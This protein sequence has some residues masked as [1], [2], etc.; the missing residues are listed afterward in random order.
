MIENFA[1]CSERLREDSTNQ[2]TNLQSIDPTTGEAI[3]SYAEH[4][5]ADAARMLESAIIAQRQWRETSFAERG[6][7]LKR[8]ATILRRDKESHAVLM[9]REMGK[10]LEQGRAEI[11]KCA[12]CC[13]FYAEHAGKFLSAEEVRTE[14]AHSYVLFQPLGVLL[15]IMPWNFPFWQVIRAAAPALMAGNGMLLKHASNVCGCALA[16]EN[17]F[18]EADLPE[19]LFSALLISSRHVSEVIAHPGVAAVTLTGSTAAGKSV[20]GHAGAHLKK[21]VLELGGSDAYVVLDDADIEAAAEICAISRLINSGQSCI[22]AKRFIVAGAVREMFQ[23]QLVEKMGARKIGN[24]I[25]PGTQIGPL[26]RGDLRD[27]LHSQVQRS[28]VAGAKVLL[29]GKVSPGAGAYYPAT[30]LANV[31]PGMAAFDEETFGPVAAIIEADNEEHAI[32]LANKSIFGLGAA[33]FTSDAT[34]GER[35]AARLEAGCCFINDFVRSDPRLP[36]GG[37][38]E[39]GYGRELAAFGIREFVNIKTVSRK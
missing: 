17:I 15:A 8:A 22:A 24:P 36:F 28:I 33:V 30:V 14:A 3:A 23:R 1:S 18:R 31:R 39:S 13:E 29:G 6:A 4:S 7:T 10:P 38:K 19:G 21:S 26:A 25:D 37:I 11:E 12:V 9:A 2:G 5:V 16:T 35:V 32:E 27:A 20:A 34:R